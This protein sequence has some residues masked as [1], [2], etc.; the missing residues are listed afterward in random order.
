MNALP[1]PLYA[2]VKNH[3]LRHIRSGAWRPGER[4]PSEHEL[5]RELNVSR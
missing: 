4:V 1:Q 5:V 3:V 2:Q